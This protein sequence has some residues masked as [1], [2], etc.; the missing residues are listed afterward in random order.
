MK[1]VH[2]GIS[3]LLM[4]MGNSIHAQKNDLAG[5][6]L[7]TIDGKDYDANTFMKVYLKNLDI[8]QDD[9]QKDVDN[10]LELYIDYRLKLQQAYKLGLDKDEAYKKELLNYRSSLSQGFLTDTEVTD[11]LVTE[12]YNRSKEEVNA[13][14]ILVKVGRGASPADTLTAWNKIIEIKKQL[15]KGADFA[16]LAREKSEGPSAGNAGELGWF[17]PFRMVYEFEDAAFETAVGKHTS[18]FRTDFGYHVLK[19]NDRRK[20]RGEVTVA[21]IMAFDKSDATDKTAENRIKDIYSQLK[22]GKAFEELAR[23]FSDDLNSA[24]NGGKLTRFG[25]GGLNSPIFED[26]ALAMTVPQEYSEPFESKYGWH[27]V[28]LIE[29]HPV[30]DFNK[31]EKILIDKI[32]KSPRS[33]K[34]TTSFTNKL[35][36]KYGLPTTS[37][38]PKSFVTAVSD[39]ILDLTWAFKYKE[40]DSAKTLT[41]IKDENLTHGSFTKFA[42]QR[43]QKDF[44]DYPTKEA[45]LNEFYN[46][47]INEEVIDYYDE[48]LE[49]DNDDFAFIYN[50]FKEGILLFNLMEKNIWDK[51]KQDTVA[52]KSY[53]NDHKS[54]YNWKRRLDIILTQNTTEEVAEEVIKMLRNNVEIDSIKSH[55]NKDGRTKVLISSGIVEEGYNR[56][57]VDFEIK[58]GVSKIYKTDTDSFYKVIKI[59]EIIEPSIKTFEEA[60]GAV[61]N[62]YQQVLEEQWKND[63]RTGH[64]IKVNK[65]T[66]KKVKKEIA[67]Q[68]NI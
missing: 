30:A 40:V 66:L 57:P 5:E 50:E 14:H 13:S 18:P 49:R 35:K 65:K 61:M 24:G 64:D 8:V 20:S 39:S 29:K 60:M 21:H 62:D 23:E 48:N 41:S 43:Q 44:K 12:V 7:L 52:L 11:Q 33:R 3:L 34:I 26:K 2:L 17:G 6:T 56:L 67:D 31:Q 68:K 25:T 46:E 47:Y 15:D 36:K 19:V 27:I 22:E 1:Q 16:A 4:L 53:Y 51:A 28:K 45:K 38:L 55:F 9:S 42:T 63:L 54:N 10:Y 58:Q 59:N 37:S 32:K